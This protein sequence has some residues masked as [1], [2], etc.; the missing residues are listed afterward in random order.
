MV[1]VILRFSDKEFFES[2]LCID[3]IQLD[4]RFGAKLILEVHFTLSF[5]SSAYE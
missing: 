3:L 2:Q 1:Y 4:I 5:I